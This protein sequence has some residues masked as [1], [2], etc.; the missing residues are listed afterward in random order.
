[1]TRFLNKRWK[2][3]SILLFFSSTTSSFGA[4]LLS[5]DQ[6][7][8][9]DEI[10]QSREWLNLLHYRKTFP[11]GVVRSQLSGPGFFFAPTGAYDSKAELLATI[12]AFFRD[13]ASG[14]F[15]SSAA[16]DRP[17]QH[18]QCAFPERLRYLKEKLKINPKPVFCP[19][20]EKMME[21]F[22]AEAT[23]LVFSSAFLGSPASMFGHTF[24]KILSKRHTDL[25]DW[26]IS[27]AATVPHEENSFLF[28]LLG[29]MGGYAG[30]YSLLPYYAKVQEYINAES[31][32]LWEYEL[33]LSPEE[34]RRLIS[35]IWELATNSWFDYYFINYNCSY[36]LLTALE[37]VKPEW[38]L[39]SHW[40][41]VAP[42]ETV[43]RLAT[44]SGAIRNVRYRP[45][46]RKKLIQKYDFLDEAEKNLFYQIQNGIKEPEQ[47]THSNVLETVALYY[48]YIKQR[49][50]K[51]ASNQ[52]QLYQRVLA[53]RST[54]DAS[55]YSSPSL[56]YAK[57]SDED[58]PEFGHSPSRIGLSIG[59]Q[60]LPFFTESGSF[61]VFQELTYKF[62]YH[63]LMNNDL[64]YLPHS[65]INFPWISIR[66]YSN[67]P[68]GEADSPGLIWLERLQFFGM[69]SLVPIQF[70]E[71]KLS[72]QF[73]AD[74]Y[75]PKDFGC[76]NCHAVRFLGGPGVTVE[77]F[78]PKVVAYF[79]NL[80]NLEYGTSLNFRFAPQGQLG[81]LMNPW[82]NYK[83][84][85]IGN[86]LWDVFPGTRQSHFSELTV[87][88]SLSMKQNFEFRSSL[89]VLIPSK[90]SLAGGGS[91]SEGKLTLHWYF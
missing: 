38:D 23:A 61:S 69:T 13:S 21:N 8:Q 12:D 27:F 82:Q 48:Q 85:L 57:P 32:D 90:P 42:V 51:L 81:L 86:V 56:S 24:L 2:L 55:S 59:A 37:V 58:R 1:M 43:K 71:K 70:I 16:I 78:T 19:E 73:Q 52:Q 65:E 64:G 53:K 25:L 63:D 11:F 33:N 28:M 77:C 66:F 30:E 20:Y 79:F 36:Q 39:S 44:I 18:P 15:E 3:L 47:I 89:S 41:F 35:H 9:V 7:S 74:Y 31:R 22:Q 87:Q 72:W 67:W 88:Q 49:D 6:L 45:S 14:G 60:S 29:L 75:S 83:L 40:F 68:Q 84:Q 50:E 4:S 54:L 91:L 34:T 80:F 5:A 46:L 76:W 17:R 10:A 26:G 62:A